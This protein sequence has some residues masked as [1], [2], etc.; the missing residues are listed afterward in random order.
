MQLSELLTVGKLRRQVR[1]SGLP[2]W[3]YL[4][5]RNNDKIFLLNTRIFV[6]TNSFELQRIL[7]FVNT[8]SHSRDGTM[9]LL[10]WM[11]SS[12]ALVLPQK[13]SRFVCCFMHH[14][15]NWNKICKKKYIS[16]AP[17]VDGKIH[18]SSFGNL[19]GDSANLVTLLHYALRMVFPFTSGTHKITLYL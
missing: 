10:Y 1:L 19:G 8:K 16:C 15:H 13:S 11:K 14:A 3:K 6:K 17:G 9:L 5:H 18:P 12:Y 4:P 7:F 2:N